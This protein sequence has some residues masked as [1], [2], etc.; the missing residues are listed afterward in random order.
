[1]FWKQKLLERFYM[2][3]PGSAQGAR[4]LLL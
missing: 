1:M 3:G 2:T 4:Q